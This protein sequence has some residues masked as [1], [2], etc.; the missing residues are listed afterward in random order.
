MRADKKRTIDA[1]T[2]EVVKNP[3]ATME[4]IANKVGVHKSNVSRN[5]PEVQQTQMYKDLIKAREEEKKR[6]ISSVDHT[7]LEIDEEILSNYIAFC[8]G[9][10]E[11][12]KEIEFIMLK[13]MNKLLSERRGFYKNTRYSIL[14]RAGFKCQACGLKPNKDN[15]VV[16]HIDHIV[17]ITRGGSNQLENLQVLCN[18]C[19]CSKGNDH[20]FNHNEDA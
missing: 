15:E 12:K 20:F 5:M 1:I 9:T 2:A 16:L 18:T 3:L 13:A 19:N 6:I 7:K 4:E 17:P 10:K 8:G 14:E 11:T